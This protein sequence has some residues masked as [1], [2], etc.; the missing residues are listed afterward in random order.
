MHFRQ[1][2]G[3]GKTYPHALVASL[4]RRAAIEELED[5]LLLGLGNPRPIVAHVDGNLLFITKTLLDSLYINAPP[6]GCVFERV[7]N[8]VV[9]DQRD[10]L[11]IT[12]DEGQGRANGP[13][14][15][16]ATVAG[17]EA[18]LAALLVH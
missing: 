13:G 6:G 3:Q 2:P 16:D 5:T 1:L 4:L 14:E 10:P 12:R 11:G 17:I 7:V 9:H 18:R 15:V 8:Q